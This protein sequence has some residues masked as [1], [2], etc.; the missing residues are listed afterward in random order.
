MK[1]V[2]VPERGAEA[3]FGTHDENLRFLE[4]A[5]K[6]RIRTQGTSCSSRATSAARR[7]SARSSSSS[8]S[9]M[10]DGYAV[11]SGDVRLAA[12]APD[13]GRRPRACATTCMRRRCAAARRRWSRAASTSARYLEQIEKHDMVFGIGPAGTGKT[14][15]A[16]A[17]AVAEPDEQV[18][19]AHRAGAPGGGGGREARLPARRPAGEGRSLPAAA[20]R[21][22]LRPARLREGVRACSSATRSR[23]RPSPSCAAAR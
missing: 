9:L 15:L 12:A 19:G 5:L 2:A 20:L 14:Y 22:A 13:A 11:A 3:L 7:R 23:W 21:R 10:K 6:V 16:V 17:Q 1:R 18:G 8:A 4:D